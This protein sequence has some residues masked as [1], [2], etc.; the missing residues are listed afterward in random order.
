[1]NTIE[2]D[3]EKDGVI[4]LKDVW[5]KSEMESIRKEYEFLDKKKDNN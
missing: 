3:F 1:M 2:K 4:L 5:K